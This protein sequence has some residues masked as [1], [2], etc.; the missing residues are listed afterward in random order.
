MPPPC[1]DH[2]LQR[3]Q[4]CD[5]ERADADDPEAGE[6][7]CDGVGVA[8]RTALLDRLQQLTDGLAIVVG[9]T[10]RRRRSLDA[11]QIDLVGGDVVVEGRRKTFARRGR[12]RFGAGRSR[13]VAAILL[14]GAVKIQTGRGASAMFSA[15]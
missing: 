7:R 4:E 5:N 6:D 15:S 2:G 9:R 10:A 11:I 3:G 13:A 1:A 12:H 8:A 14:V